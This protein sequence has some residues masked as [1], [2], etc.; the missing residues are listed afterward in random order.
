MNYYFVCIQLIINNYQKIVEKD[1]IYYNIIAIKR[2][3]STHFLGRNDPDSYLRT[4]SEKIWLLFIFVLNWVFLRFSWQ[5]QAFG[6]F[7]ASKPFMHMPYNISIKFHLILSTL[8]FSRFLWQRRP[9]NIMCTH[10]RPNFWKASSN[11]EHF[12]CSW[13][14]CGF[15]SNGSHL[16]NSE[17]SLHIYS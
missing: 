16:E 7:Q 10:V 8:N 9:F 2:G 4:N 14:F 12:N 15:H 13:F 1:F 3:E 6:N 11:S 17:S 5:W